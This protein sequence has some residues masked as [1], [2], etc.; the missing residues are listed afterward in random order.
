MTAAEEVKI[1]GDVVL[2]FTARFLEKDVQ[3]GRPVFY[4][5]TKLSVLKMRNFMAVLALRIEDFALNPKSMSFI[6]RD[7]GLQIPAVVLNFERIG[8][9]R[10]KIPGK[11]TNTENFRW[12]LPIPVKPKIRAT[13][14]QKAK[15]KTF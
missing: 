8:S 14:G 2:G 11:E 3:P 13:R 12:T 9:A 6:A 5:R 7:F 10:R 1:P 15:K 4:Q